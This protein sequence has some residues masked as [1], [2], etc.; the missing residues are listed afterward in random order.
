M[1]TAFSV[2]CPRVRWA[3][4]HRFRFPVLRVS[5]GVLTE[6]SGMLRRRAE[7]GEDVGQMKVSPT[8]ELLWFTRPVAPGVY[9]PLIILERLPSRASG[10]REESRGTCRSSGGGTW[11]LPRK[12]AFR[13]WPRLGTCRSTPPAGAASLEFDGT[14]DPSADVM[15]I[16]RMPSEMVRARDKMVCAASTL[17]IHYK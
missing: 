7:K 13:T 16:P 8:L 3:D 1:R 9:D 4:A 15:N 14:T 12:G 6:L 10:C 5:N 2:T 11:S 17:I